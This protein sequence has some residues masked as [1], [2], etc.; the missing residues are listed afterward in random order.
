MTLETLRIAVCEDDAQERQQFI[1]IL[2]QSQY[3]VAV[4]EFASGQGFLAKFH[5]YQYDLI[6]MDIF[7]DGLSG[8]EVITQVRKV[9]PEVPV[10]FITSS[11]DFAR[12]SYRLDALKYIE[13]P[14]AAKIVIE[15]LQLAQ[16]KQQ[17][18][19]RL[20]IRSAGGA[21]SY[22][23]LQILYMEQKGRNLMI[24][25]SGGQQVT[26][27]KKLDEVADQLSDKY[28]FR[29]HKSYLVN[30]AFV[31]GIDPTLS[32]FTMTQGDKVHIRRESFCRAKK[33]FETYLFAKG[34][35]GTHG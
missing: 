33:A 34:Q 35:G 19:E 5:P 11:P 24:F 4:S 26:V 16:L 15:A 18:V 27:T 21:V 2:D 7:M 9:D 17:T 10:A 13:K 20:I 12:E 3:P 14:V 8:I 25:L 30:L 1:A 31:C 22:P 29:C 28:F 32:T 6:F 23:A